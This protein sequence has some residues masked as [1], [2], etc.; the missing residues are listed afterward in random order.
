M[1]L[2]LVEFA[3]RV[4]HSIAFQV[5]SGGTRTG[6]NNSLTD[7]L[8]GGVGGMSTPT[9]RRTVQT[10]QVRQRPYSPR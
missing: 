3:L 5:Q 10:F 2:V 9:L 6:H 8:S 1:I 4:C 7:D